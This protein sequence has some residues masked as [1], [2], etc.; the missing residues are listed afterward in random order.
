MY[1][2]EKLRF[3]ITRDEEKWINWL[4]IDMCK[5]F[6]IPCQKAEVITLKEQSFIILLLRT[7]TY[8]I[9]NHILNY[10]DTVVVS[11]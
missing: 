9:F 4:G 7:H 5:S 6:P 8:T 3:P 1:I 2:N 10:G 11:I